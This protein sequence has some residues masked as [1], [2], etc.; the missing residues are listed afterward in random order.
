MHEWIPRTPEGWRGLLL[1]PTPRYAAALRGA[2]KAGS[3]APS[4]MRLAEALPAKEPADARPP[5]AFDRGPPEPS[6]REL[7]A[8]ARGARQRHEPR[9]RAGRRERRRDR[10]ERLAPDPV[11]PPA[12]LESA[13]RSFLASQAKKR[14][15]KPLAFARPLKE[16]SR[17][18]PAG[19]SPRTPC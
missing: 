11:L 4:L 7:F 6:L 16:A 17:K 12:T 2:R 13:R 3:G 19:F 15:P 8:W 18:F 10:E 14:A 5:E 9:D 1:A